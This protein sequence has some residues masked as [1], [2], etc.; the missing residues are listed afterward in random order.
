[1]HVQ[2]VPMVYL[3]WTFIL[4]AIGY[5]AVGAIMFFAQRALMYFPEGVRTA[6]AAAGL[7]R[8]EEVMLDS[9][10]EKIIVWH[11]PPRGNKPVVLYFHG[12]GGALRLRTDR[13][14]KLAADGVGLVGL[15]Y[16]GYGGSTGQPT[17]AGLI[18]DARAAYAFAA[19]RY[20]GRIVA[21]GESL[22]T[23]VAIALAAEKPVSRLILESPYTSTVDVAAARYWFLPVRF[24]MKDQFRSDL[25][26]THVTA[27]VLIMHGDADGIIPI[28]YGQRLFA[29][30]PGKKRMV[31]FPGGGHND[32]DAFGAFGVAMKF[33][34]GKE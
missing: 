19:A 32:L 13:F 3:K 34:E 15:S 20:P 26:I 8:A 2:W 27:P 14:K 7:P 28:G 10:A 5:L 33:I 21:W 30:I 11:L 18:E 22:G 25:R 4:A 31:R 17:E 24:L 12:N 16:R 23:G 9:G 29:L 1:M 6:P